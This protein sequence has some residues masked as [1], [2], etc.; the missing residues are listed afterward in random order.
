MASNRIWRVGG[1]TQ[2]QRVEL[3]MQAKA[4]QPCWRGFERACGSGRALGLLVALGLSACASAP[5]QTF[6]LSDPPVHRGGRTSPRQ[7][8]VSEPVTSAAF[9][10]DRIVVR[11]HANQIA[12][13]SGVQWSDRLPTLVQTRLIEALESAQIVRSVGRP[14]ERLAADVTLECEIR[15]FEVDVESNAAT[16]ELSVK[17]VSP[18]TGRLIAA[19]VFSAHAPV[20]G[21]AGAVASSALDTAFSDVQRQIVGWAAGKI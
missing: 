9:D 3:R 6:D 13:L 14:S 11:P 2:R 18:Q 5:P 10:S 8:V 7:L 20:T 1:H 12:Y 17:L 4:T 19:N 15:A 16:V 21:T